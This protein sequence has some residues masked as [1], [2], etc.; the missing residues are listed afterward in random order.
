MKKQVRVRRVAPH[1]RRKLHQWKRLLANQVNSCHARIILLSSGGFANCEIARLVD[2]TPQWVRVIIHRFNRGGLSGI[3]WYPYWQTRDTP[4]KFFADVVEQM[5]E[6]A[7][8]TPKRLIGMTQWSLSKLREYLVSQRIISSVSLNWLRTLLKRRGV[9]WRHT[10][11]WKKSKDPQFRY[12]Y[13]RIRRLY[14]RRPAGGSRICV[15][16]F[17]P[18][19][20]EPRGGNCLSKPHVKPVERH[21]ATYNRL[22]GVRHFLAAYDL[23]TGRL[24]GQ[25]TKHKTWVEFLAFLKWLRRRYKASETLHIVQDNYSPHL[26]QEVIA[27]AKTHKVKFYWTPTNASWMNRIECQFT[28]MRKFALNNSDYRSHEEQQAAIES[29]LAWRNG[30][31]NIA[32]ESWQAHLRGTNEDQTSSGQPALAI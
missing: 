22:R 13:R 29:Y 11:T 30:R 16:E 23:E 25:F 28:A 15:D 14:G 4:R 19:N 26:K 21:R 32:V 24:V 5:A 18:L 1:E 8:C 12:K 3:E 2:R 31:R 27:W 20:L 17:G 7:L 10:K 6:V 9:H